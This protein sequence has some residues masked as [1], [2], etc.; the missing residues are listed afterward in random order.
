[1]KSTGEVLGVGKNL[2]EALFKGLVSAGFKTDFHKKDKHGV[3]ITVTKQ[4]R[5]EIV[6]LAKKLDDLGAV[7]WATPETAK[8]IESLGIKVGV[9][10]KLREDN[11]IMG[12]EQYK[13]KHHTY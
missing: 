8:A 4:D 12:P 3:L 11:S 10:N 13:D 5:F 7:I 2:A 1:M 9:V 6:N